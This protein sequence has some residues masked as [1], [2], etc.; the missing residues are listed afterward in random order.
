MPGAGEQV[1][2]EKGKSITLDVPKQYLK[3][4]KDLTWLLKE[5]KIVIVKYSNN[6][7][8]TPYKS[9]VSF[10]RENCSLTLKNLTVKDNG[11]YEAIVT[12]SRGK[13]NPQIRY[14]LEV[15]APVSSLSIQVNKVRTPD[16]GC[17]FTLKCS[18]EKGTHVSFHWAEEDTKKTLHSDTLELTRDS[19]YSGNNSFTCFAQNNVSHASVTAKMV[20]CAMPSA[21]ME[22]TIGVT[23]ALLLILILTTA[24]VLIFWRKKCT[25]NPAGALYGN[26]SIE[27]RCNETS[28]VTLYDTVN[29]RIQTMELEPGVTTVYA[30]ATSV[31]PSEHAKECYSVVNHNAQVP[32]TEAETIYEVVQSPAPEMGYKRLS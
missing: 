6:F 18:A 14:K 20:E 8:A 25:K 15:Q 26:V 13:E 10:H 29:P 5:S 16:G 22:T 28:V 4:M 23:T 9:R 7:M 2:G 27:K 19:D 21:G 31:R 3:D 11:E 17:N 1:Y 32:L 24:V 12:D 30:T